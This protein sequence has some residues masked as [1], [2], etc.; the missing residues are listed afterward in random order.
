MICSKEL[1]RLAT[2]YDMT[3]V[4]ILREAMNLICKLYVPG[5]MELHKQKSNVVELKVVATKKN[6]AASMPSTV[7]T[8]T[9][10]E[11]LDETDSDFNTE[12]LR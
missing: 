6:C 10:S 12:V 8:A 4:Q 1:Q 7:S 2:K 11:S 5:E 9:A 3:E